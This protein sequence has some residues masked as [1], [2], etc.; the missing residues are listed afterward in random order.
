MIRRAL[1]LK[2]ALNTYVAQLRGSKDALDKEVSDNDYLSDDEWHAL[3]IIKDHLKPLFYMTKALEGNAD[4]K[5]GTCKA[6]HGSLWELLLVFEHV[7]TH[8]E[9]LQKRSTASEFGHHPGI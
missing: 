6:S 8:F 7:L 5:D 9:K 1:E 4:L 3:E 2:E